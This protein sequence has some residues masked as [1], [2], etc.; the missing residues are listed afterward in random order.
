MK[1]TLPFKVIIGVAAK[2]PDVEASF[3]IYNNKASTKFPSQV[4]LNRLN[5]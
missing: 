3:D 2:M 1:A 5:L 4:R